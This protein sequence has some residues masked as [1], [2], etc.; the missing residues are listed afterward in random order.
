MRD[1]T[2]AVRT[3][4]VVWTVGVT[5]V[6]AGMPLMVR[7]RLPDPLA[8]HWG[9][10]GGVPDGSMPL[11]AASLFPALIWLLMAGVTLGLLLRGRT[12]SHHPWTAA[13][14]LPTGIV[15]AGSQAALVRAN[16]D[17][18]HWQ[19][20]RQPTAWI[21]A[22]LVAAVVAGVGAWFVATRRPADTAAA[23]AHASGVPA[24]DL[25]DGRRVV[26]FSRTANPWLRLVAAVTGLAAAGALVAV[27]GGL[28]DPGG[29]WAAFAGCAVASLSCAL[30][31]SVQARVSERGLEVSF[32]PFG[33]PARRWAPG[34][35]EVARAE[36]RSPA[37]VGGW[38]Y[39]V[40]GLGTTVMLRA[41]E[42]LVIRPRGRR[43]DFAVSVDDAERGAALLN[44]VRA[45]RAS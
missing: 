17:R 27:V 40:S 26:W 30:F 20:A 7:G 25:P 9:L 18:A 44:A 5:A 28:A 34:D 21:V 35:I 11:W 12:G 1:T 41:G 31:S 32:G 14:L 33:R 19:E 15:L 3:T 23:G 10:S 45:G 36:V 16:L 2:V 38:G 8:T 43:T 39:R 29:L 37:Q 24:L 4:A 42:C 13:T 22:V 6:L